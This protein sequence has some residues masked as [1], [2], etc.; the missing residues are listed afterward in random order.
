MLTT[1]II[2][3]EEVFQCEKCLAQKT[4]P[5]A[6]Q[7]IREKKGCFGNSAGGYKLE[8]FRF[9]SCI[10]NFYSPAVFYWYRNFKNFQKGILPFS[11]SLFDQPGKAI[12][13]FQVFESLD[14]K[15]AQELDRQA[16]IKQ[17][18]EK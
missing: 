12:E 8:N 16:K 1:H 2:I 11:G 6:L 3:N 5:Q 15:H 4:S 14:S 10:G 18:N 9:K 7:V 17:R 13:I